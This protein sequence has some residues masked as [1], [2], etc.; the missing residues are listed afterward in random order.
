MFVRPTSDRNDVTRPSEE[1][2]Q[3]RDEETLSCL[4]RFYC[5]AGIIM[6]TLAFVSLY[7]DNEIQAVLVIFLTIMIVAVLTIVLVR[8]R[9]HPT[10]R[11][12]NRM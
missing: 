10:S 12:K 8:A 6:T 1:S 5:A 3:T 9:Q 2:G 4:D 7:Q 11:S